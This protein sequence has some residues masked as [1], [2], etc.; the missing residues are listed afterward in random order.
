MD[1][2]KQSQKLSE[3][4]TLSN[5]NAMVISFEDIK[6]TD[7]KDFERLLKL[8]T[9]YS[10]FRLRQS[11]IKISRVYH[12]SIRRGQDEKFKGIVIA[13]EFLNYLSENEKSNDSRDDLINDWNRDNKKEVEEKLLNYKQI[14]IKEYTKI[15]EINPIGFRI[16]K[17]FIN[18]IFFIL[19]I[20]MVAVYLNHAIS[21][22]LNIFGIIFF[23]LFIMGLI[24]KFFKQSS[25]RILGDYRAFKY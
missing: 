8:K 14:S 1:I 4:K 20:I 10:S 2:I 19:I 13:Y 25:G 6:E 18:T 9:E 16:F 17:G 24:V 12:P 22:D 7:I 3:V 23:G 11:F 15:I 5:N 21:G